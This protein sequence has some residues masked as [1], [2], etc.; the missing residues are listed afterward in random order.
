[1]VGERPPCTAKMELSIT[2]D[3]LRGK[4][5]RSEVGHL[6]SESIKVGARMKHL[7]RFEAVRRS[8]GRIATPL[9]TAM[10]RFIQMHDGHPPTICQDEYPST[11][12]PLFMPCVPPFLVMVWESLTPNIVVGVEFA[13]FPPQKGRPAKRK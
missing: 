13:V 6:N 11:D 8:R 4:N 7:N 5:S 3:R 10:R 9:C 2:A 1:M 12:L